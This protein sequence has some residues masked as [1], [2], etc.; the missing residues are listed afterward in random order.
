MSNYEE[1]EE[2]AAQHEHVLS[3]GEIL[4]IQAE[5]RAQKVKAAI[6]PW[7][8]GTGFTACLVASMVFLMTSSTVEST[9]EIVAFT[10]AIE[11]IE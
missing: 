4:A 11:E 1:F 5:Y 9:A 2:I 10:Q 6:I 7:V 8:V 3:E